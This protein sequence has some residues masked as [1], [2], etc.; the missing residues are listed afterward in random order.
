MNTLGERK[1]EGK[2]KRREKRNKI[3]YIPS[4]QIKRKD[5][6]RERDRKKKIK[7]STYPIAR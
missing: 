2:K 3:I 7:V 1:K 4:S 6:G 5:R